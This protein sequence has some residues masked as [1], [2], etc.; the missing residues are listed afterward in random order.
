MPGRLA[1]SLATAIGQTGPVSLARTDALLL[2]AEAGQRLRWG[3]WPTAAVG[4]LAWVTTVLVLDSTGGLL[5]QRALGVGTWA[6]LI[7][8]LARERALV[9][10]QTGVVVAFATAVE[11]TFSP[12][13]GVYAYRFD[14]VPAYVPPGHGL[15]YLA[16]L[17]LGRSAWVRG[18]LGQCVTAV[19]ALGGGYA[20]WGL[21]LAPRP[22]VLGA[23]W[24]VCLV[25]FLAW[26]PSRTLYVGAFVV[27]TYLE[28]VGTTLGTWT[29]SAHDPTG[30]VPIGNPPSGAAGGYGWFDLAALLA[31]PALLRRCCYPMFTW[32]SGA[33]HGVQPVGSVA[34]PLEVR[35]SR[36][37]R[38]SQP[39]QRDRRTSCAEGPR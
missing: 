22:D 7:G 24:F 17:G 11:Y 4:V 1:P 14:N 36:P 9:R 15:V 38:A 33:S 35:A 34:E 10:I 27:V 30:L 23:F 20:V 8:V 29:W 16:A 13:L 6:I 39:A 21:L 26:G 25:G 19:V 12:L 3:A 18:H 32:D 37:G 28:L 2:R 31:S 5:E